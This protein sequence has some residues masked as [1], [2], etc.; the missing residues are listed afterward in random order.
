MAFST[1]EA[2]SVAA[3]AARAGAEAA[4][5]DPEQAARLE[6][7]LAGAFVDVFRA[8]DREKSYD[9]LRLNRDMLAA[10]DAAI[11]RAALPEAATATLRRMLEERRRA[12]PACAEE[13]E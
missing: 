1:E 5:L 8:H 6:A 10:A 13:C 4:K 9:G 12:P 7:A 2:R 11:A 3:R